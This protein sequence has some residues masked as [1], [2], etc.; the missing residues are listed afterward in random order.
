M[1]FLTPAIPNLLYPSTLKPPKLTKYP[2]GTSE[3]PY[4]INAFPD[5]VNIKIN[6]RIVLRAETKTFEFNRFRPVLK[7]IFYHYDEF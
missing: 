5:S 1:T 2:G 3:F 4:C 6:C 7:S